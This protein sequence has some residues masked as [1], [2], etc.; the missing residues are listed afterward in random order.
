MPSLLPDYEYDI[1]ISCRQNDN[2][3][4]WVAQF[5]KDLRE[6]YVRDMLRQIGKEGDKPFRLEEKL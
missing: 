5:V 2:R 6:E 3:S 1:F 4:G